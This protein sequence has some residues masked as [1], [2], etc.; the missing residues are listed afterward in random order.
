LQTYR[1]AGWF[2][3]ADP[4]EL[5]AAITKYHFTIYPTKLGYLDGNRFTGSQP[6]YRMKL[7]SRQDYLVTASRSE[8][9]K[10]LASHRWIY[11]GVLGYVWAKRA[12]GTTLMLR[13]DNGRHWR[14]I[15]HRDLARFQKAGY[16]I[17][18]PLGY[19]LPVR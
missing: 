9:T 18:G 7:K 13:V 11:E 1:K 8:R 5:H 16:H 2:Y 12:K 17:D 19:V 6:L 14:V 3:T 15:V 4:P 10:L